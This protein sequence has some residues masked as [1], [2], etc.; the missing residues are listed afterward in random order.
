[1]GGSS[2]GSLRGPPPAKALTN[3]VSEQVAEFF[4]SAVP[5]LVTAL[6]AKLKVPEAAAY[7]VGEEWFEAIMAVRVDS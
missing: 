5:G 2:R 7:L 3:R 1:M 6:A 4:E